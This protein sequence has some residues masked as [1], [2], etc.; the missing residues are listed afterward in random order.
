MLIL[1]FAGLA[2]ALAAI[3]IYGVMS[4]VVS[5]RTRELGIRMAM[6]AT[7]QDVLRLIIVHGAKLISV[8][9]GIGLIG[10]FAASRILRGV[11]Y[12]VSPT[13]PVTYLLVPL[14]LIV[15]ALL[16]C[17]I[18]ARRATR[19]DPLV[20]LRNEQRPQSFPRRTTPAD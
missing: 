16:A 2:L 7:Q 14:F 4:Y 6:G 15:I 9:I 8:G 12:G 13:D 17:L 3:G 1:I 10:A 20:A 19:V 11:L 5:Q 18:P